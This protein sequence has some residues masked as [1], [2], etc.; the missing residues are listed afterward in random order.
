MENLKRISSALLGL[1]M[2][3]VVLLLGNKYVIDVALSVVALISLHEYF[4]AFSNNYKPIQW[5]G[6]LLYILFQR[7][8][9]LKL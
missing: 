7:K 3:I 9:F 4:N 2:V 5:L 1:P 6:Y 8:C